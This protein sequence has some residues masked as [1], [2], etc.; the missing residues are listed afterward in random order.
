[1]DRS[2]LDILLADTTRPQLKRIIWYINGIRAMQGLAPLKELRAP[3]YIL[4]PLQKVNCPFW[5]SCVDTEYITP[6]GVAALT[7]YL[8][9]FGFI[10]VTPP[11]LTEWRR[12]HEQLWHA[13]L[14]ERTART[15]G[16]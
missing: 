15:P 3:A 4:G 1:M 5:L 2:P 16:Y 6:E 7:F 13:Q 8:E 9:H 10:A 12:K 14:T 11:W